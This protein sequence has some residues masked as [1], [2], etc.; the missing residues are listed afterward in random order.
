[1]NKIRVAVFGYGHLGKWHCQKVDALKDLAELCFIVEQKEENKNAA[2]I[3]H[4]HAEV[5]NDYA[6]II[7]SFDAAIVVTPTTTHY[8][9][10]KELLKAGKHVFCEK[11]L[12]TNLDECLDLN[13]YISPKQILQVGH[14]ERCHASWDILKKNLESLPNKTLIKFTRK[15][16]FKGRAMDVDVVQ[17]LAIHDLDLL[18]YLFNKK[19]KS[20]YAHGIKIRTS[21]DDHVWID[22]ELEHDCRAIVEVGRNATNEVRE[23]EIVSAQGSITVDLFRNKI[24]IAPQDQV[25]NGVYVEEASYEKRDHL[26]VEHASFYN[27]I[28]KNDK[29]LVNY[30]DACN[31]IK[32]MGEITQSL[33]TG[34]RVTCE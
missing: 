27:S 13:K 6:N 17:D 24:I 32:L 30:Q 33:K 8:A 21:N 29:V 19:I 20:V 34:N 14:S 15:A 28:L 2:K 3:A 31:V 23:L 11:P 4:P 16:P 25:S 22:L 1:M 5:V 9:I 12:T 10:V 26:Y 7:S 18:L